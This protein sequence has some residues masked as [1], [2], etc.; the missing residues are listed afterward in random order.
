MTPPSSLPSV[1]GRGSSLAPDLAASALPIPK[2]SVEQSPFGLSASDGTGL[3]LLELTAQA[4]VE[5]PLAFTEIRLVFE[6]PLNR[7]LEGTFRM[8]LPEHASIS[9]FAMRIDDRWQEG[10]IV[11]K[12][13]AR[14][15]FEDFLHRKQDPALLED[16][17]A[18]SF[19]ARVFP[20]PPLGR[21]ELILSY[22]QEL[23][24]ETPYR[25][26]LQGLPELGSVHIR[27]FS[28]G[29][30]NPIGEFQAMN[31]SPQADFT[32]EPRGPK[33]S[34]VGLRHGE[35]MVARVSPL[36]DTAPDPIE[37]AIFL[38]D[39]SASRAL[40]FADQLDVLQHLIEE[41]A[42]SS[43]AKTPI[44]VACFDQNVEPIFEGEAGAF[45]N[46][47]LSKIYHRGA[48]G[49]S[50]MGSALDWAFKEAERSHKKRLIV[51]GDG[52]VNT[53]QAEAGEIRAK[54]GALGRA[55]IERVDAIAF[56]GIRDSILLHHLSTA[57]LPKDGIVVDG[58][59]RAG[60]LYRRLSEGTN[61]PLPVKVEHA[62]WVWPS[63]LSG[64]QAGDS[65]LVY[66]QIPE[67]IQTPTLTIGDR[68]FPNIKLERADR[69]LL[70]RAWAKAKI[71]SLLDRQAREGSVLGQ[72]PIENQIIALSKTYRVLSPY[73]SLLVLESESDY[74]QFQIER[75]S[76][77]D[78][79][80]IDG[81]K[82]SIQRRTLNSSRPIQAPKSPQN[83]PEQESAR[84]GRLDEIRTPQ[85]LGNSN[86]SSRQQTQGRGVTGGGRL[87]SPSR[88]VRPPSVRM[89]ATKVSGRMPPE[90]IRGVIRRNF[91][92]FRYCY[93]QGLR[94]SPNLSAR[95]S[96]RFLIERDGTV[97]DVN[98]TD[99]N[100]VD[101]KVADCIARAVAEL[102]FPE[103]ENG[104][105]TVIYP[106]LFVPSQSDEAANEA[107][108][109]SF[110]TMNRPRIRLPESTPEKKEMPPDP[111]P[112]T[113]RFKVVMDALKEGKAQAAFQEA[114]A[115]VSSSP[116]DIPALLSLG[117]SFEALNDLKQA[118]RAYGSI[119][120]L[121][122]SRADLRRYAGAR[123]ER[124]KQSAA[125]DLAVDTYKKA[126]KDR[127][128][129]P[130]SHRLL[131]F[132]FL[133]KG[134]YE[135]A[136]EAIRLGYSKYY[137]SDRFAGVYSILSEDM[138]LVA[139]AWLKAEPSRRE[140][141][142][143]RLYGAGAQLEER[144]SIR[145]VLNWETDA[146]DVD[147]HI[148][149]NEGGHA[150][151]GQRS[152][153]KG[154]MLYADIRT[155]YGPE[156]FTIRLP[157]EE[158]AKAYTLGAHYYSQ[159]PMGYGMGKVQI[160]DHDGQGGLRFEERPF[161]AMDNQAY[162]DL[163]QVLR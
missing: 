31:F 5:Q 145:F 109:L 73:T 42:R 151:F 65:V 101:T 51:L 76:L 24:R 133:K 103:P 144:P 153:G 11:E 9:R 7:T 119:I 53:G 25:F 155:G 60:E 28:P 10:E 64:L 143:G 47:E 111:T 30:T 18:N 68:A 93:E 84:Q 8:T 107:P 34:P 44:S 37:N 38:V 127:P 43:G 163:G 152:L 138:G 55:G 12:T 69:A 117:E 134:A 126:A 3:K 61:E 118:A 14:E 70:E 142:L 150:Y 135:Q 23:P 158:R 13:R 1:S 128:D 122:A 92:R 136:F 41:L 56:G 77:G 94:V 19:S 46:K 74:K 125:L 27:V 116:G 95:V 102:S 81:G 20:I 90:V 114:R 99:L 33:L 98:V 104:V 124:L 130:S 154:G 156:C 141:I 4:V 21:K 75:L 32:V 157:R 96:L 108:P 147:F 40:G 48:L 22:S 89:A 115:W 149:D 88:H 6:N 15:V 162:I 79:L 49:A 62:R 78:I 36:P 140:E 146:N 66:A 86:G 45:G 97:S 105:I 148:Y 87:L 72:T 67:Y 26:A 106:I 16:A 29:N 58:T 100:G 159:G 54:A 121:Y 63:T 113:G 112:Y 123:L 80:G 39:T 2:P 59:L 17:G 71:D 35:L 50:D 137:P 139:A 132:A 82:I 129:H 161:I 83:P 52:V 160:I 131:G 57:G 120:D 91:G 110:G 85:S